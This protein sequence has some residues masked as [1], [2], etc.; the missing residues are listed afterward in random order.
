M[1][2]LDFVRTINASETTRRAP[3]G[4]V[5]NRLECLSLLL[6][7]L[8]LVAGRAG[9]KAAVALI[10]EAAV[11][12]APGR[13]RCLVAGRAG[14]LA[15][16]AVVGHANEGL[17]GR[18]RAGAEARGH[19]RNRRNRAGADKCRGSEPASKMSH[20]VFSSEGVD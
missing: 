14:A 4:L 20:E 2:G 9:A 15:A 12:A 10:G 19:G 5:S 1:S 17:P 7:V 8:G 6:G 3:R 18:C 11:A 16:V 13:I